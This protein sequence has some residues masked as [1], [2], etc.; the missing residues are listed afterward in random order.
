MKKTVCGVLMLFAFSVAA[1]ACGCIYL[2][3]FCKSIH[4][5][6]WEV[7]LHPEL[8]STKLIDRPKAAEQIS[9]SQRYFDL[10]IYLKLSIIPIL[11]LVDLPLLALA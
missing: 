9:I 1:K 4:R 6:A 10:A 11:S 8:A 2:E 3:T 7:Q 5:F